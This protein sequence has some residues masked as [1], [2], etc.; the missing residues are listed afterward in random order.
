MTTERAI[1]K[2][3][4]ERGEDI[5]LTASGI[6]EFISDN[7]NVTDK[8]VMMFAALCKSQRLNP[9]IR[10][11]YLVK[12][13]NQPATMIVG[14]DVLRKRAQRNPRFK[15]MEEGVTIIGSDGAMHR[16]AGSL[17][18]AGETIVGG[19]CRVYMEGFEVPMFAEVSFDEFA[20]RKK[21][22]S[23]NSMWQTKPGVMITK[24]AE[25]TALRAAMPE[26]LA[27]LYEAEE[28]QV[29]PEVLPQSN[30][31]PQ[32]S[33]SLQDSA[34]APMEAVPEMVQA[35]QA[36]EVTYEYQ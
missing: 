28:M 11:A 22:G 13:G 2:Y 33:Q 24:V 20:G 9:F 5:T 27:Q 14:R 26:D 34:E 10:E 18:L 21:D 19:W 7:P 1:A 8:E 6:R 4:T 25:A 23:L 35:D 30:I 17:V 3:T 29:N 36:E 15:G 16:R 32:T 12:Y 31:D